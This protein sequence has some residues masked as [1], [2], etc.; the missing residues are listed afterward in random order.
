MDIRVFFSLALGAVLGVIMYEPKTIDMD[1]SLNTNIPVAS[2]E[3]S[4][5]YELNTNG[6]ASVVQSQS[7][8]LFKDKEEFK[9]AYMISQNSKKEY[10]ILQSQMIKKKKENVF[11][12]GD[13]NLQ[14]HLGIQLESSELNLNTK[15]N[16]IRSKGTFLI[17]FQNS[18]YEG[19]KL[20]LNLNN[21]Q[22]IAKENK[23]KIFLGDS[24][25]TK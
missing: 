15:T 13:V 2:F 19:E 23:I 22:M 18:R 25:E 11:L 10:S 12:S 7:A 6:V 1:S 8:K 16:I 3:N 17:T 9:K 4:T 20:Y 24:Y 21:N 5:L 14:N